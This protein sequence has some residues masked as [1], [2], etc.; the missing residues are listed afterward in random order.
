MI[1]LKKNT[2]EHK[3]CVLILSTSPVWNI[4]DSKKNECSDILSYMYIHLHREYL[5][6][7]SDL[8]EI[9]FFDIFFK[10]TQISDFMKIQPVGAE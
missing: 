4:S 3:M 6:F 5:L 9:W 1:V 2:M 7:L 8:S 10:N